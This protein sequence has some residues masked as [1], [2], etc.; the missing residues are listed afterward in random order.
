MLQLRGRRT[1]LTLQAFQRGGDG[2]M[3]P[4]PIALGQRALVHGV[5]HDLAQ[6]ISPALARCPLVIFSMALAQR[7]DRRL[8]RGS[9][10][11]VEH[12]IDD[13][14]GAHLADVEVALLEVL[15]LIF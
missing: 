10:D 3:W 6:G 11:W 15:V 8:E 1:E 9:S 5:K 14:H 12:A 2:D 13:E 4:H 7:V